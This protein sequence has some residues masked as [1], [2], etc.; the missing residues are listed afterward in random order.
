MGWSGGSFSRTNGTHTGTTVWQQDEAA[1]VNIEADI[2]DTHDQDLADGINACLAKDGSNAMTGN[3]DLGGYTVENWASTNAIGGSTAASTRLS[4]GG[5]LPVSSNTTIGIRSTG[6][7]PSTA[8]TGY[9]SFYTGPATQDAAFTIVDLTHYYADQGTITGGS[10]TAPTNQYGFNAPSSLI[11]ATNNYGFY[12]GIP[13]DT[14]RWNFYA[15]G[16]AKNY[17][18]GGLHIGSTSTNNLL[19]DAS[20]GA[21]TTTLYIGNQAI[22]TSSDRR[23]KTD[24]HDTAMNALEVI[25]ALRVVDFGWNDPTDTAENNRNA[26]GQWTGLIAQEAVE[27]LPFVVNAPRTASGQIDHDSDQRWFLEYQH[28][29]P[30]LIKA[31]QQLTDR[32]EA[33]ELRS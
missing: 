33:L 1:L 3:L 18:A 11:G 2:H 16:S 29:V 32:I 7:V 6:T 15:A 31:I 13:A 25:D 19:D 5:T 23:V 24:I 17:M 22:T 21:G 27:V 12:G 14:N 8:T 30:V 20:T 10:R 26:R 28:V 4:I 9:Y